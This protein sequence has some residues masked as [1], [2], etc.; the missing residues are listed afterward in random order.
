MSYESELSTAELI[1]ELEKAREDLKE[2]RRLGEDSSVI[3]ANLDFIY[4]LE[5]ELDRRR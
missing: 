5:A 1:N 3:N 2:D 4:R